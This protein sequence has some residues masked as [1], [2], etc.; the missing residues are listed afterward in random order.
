MGIESLEERAAELLG[1]IH[2]SV[3]EAIRAMNEA[4]ALRRR[5]ADE[6]HRQH[7][8]A[9]KKLDAVKTAAE[10]L[11]KNNQVV[12]ADIRDG[13]RSQIGRV[14][15][16]VAAA[17]AR[18]HADAVV[19]AVEGRA[20]DLIIQ[21]NQQVRQVA[22]VNRSLRWK[23]VGYAGLIAV[24]LCLLVVPLSL[25]L[26]TRAMSTGAAQL[27]RAQSSGADRLLTLS[28]ADLRACEVGGKSRL[29][30]RIDPDLT[31]AGSKPGQVFAVVQ[32]Y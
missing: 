21:L 23:T 5:E 11:L 14:A 8:E 24:G 32:G 27:V 20:K 4:S 22:E 17:Q 6:A 7:D 16:E 28:E 9:Q 26:G 18:Q 15:V 3:G 12:V 2:A 31:V 30:V 13:W 25:F 29:C 10:L 1:Q 19:G